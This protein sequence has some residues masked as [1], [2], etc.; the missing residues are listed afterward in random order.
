MCRD[1]GVYAITL[2]RM[3]SRLGVGPIRPQR[4]ENDQ[5]TV[6]A[7]EVTDDIVNQVGDLIHTRLSAIR[8]DSRIVLQHPGSTYS[9]RSSPSADTGGLCWNVDAVAGITNYRNG[10]HQWAI[11]IAAT[12]DGFVVAGAVIAPARQQLWSAAR[13]EGARLLHERRAT[14]LNLNEQSESSSLFAVHDPLSILEL[15]DTEPEWDQRDLRSTGASTL[16]ICDV[17]SGNLAAIVDPTL[18]PWDHCTWDAAALI[19]AEAGALVRLPD[20]DSAHPSR[21]STPLTIAAP[22]SVNS[23]LALSEHLLMS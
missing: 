16:D 6:G 20:T 2:Y 9:T 13:G 23:A 1:A 11:S 14:E 10:H 4:T 18:R 7:L 3:A 15:P 8:P 21:A 19:A 5:H 17:A 22:H 12:V